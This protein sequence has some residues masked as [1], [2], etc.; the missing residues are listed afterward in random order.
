MNLPAGAPWKDVT[1][2]GGYWNCE[3][4]LE[5]LL[6]YVRPWFANILVVVQKSPDNTLEVAHG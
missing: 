6:T 5:R 4:R 3:E 1:F 2:T